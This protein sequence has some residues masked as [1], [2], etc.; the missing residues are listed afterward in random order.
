[1]GVQI[2]PGE[3]VILGVDIRWTT[4]TVQPV[5]KLLWALVGW[6]ELNGAFNTI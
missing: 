3:G 6:L 2:I 5:P 4:V 1:M